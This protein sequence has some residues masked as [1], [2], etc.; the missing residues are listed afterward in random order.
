MPNVVTLQ[1][2]PTMYQTAAGTVLLTVV[3]GEGQDGLSRVTLDG[4]EL[5]MSETIQQL[6]IGEG[7][8]L[9]G[10]KLKVTTSVTAR[11]PN[12][13]RTIVTYTLEGGAAQRSHPSRGPDTALNV[14]VDFVARFEFE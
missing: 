7:P 3:V 9:I 10:K 12:S 1:P 4:A 11:N 5:A 6:E 2:S 13:R 8:E 14:T